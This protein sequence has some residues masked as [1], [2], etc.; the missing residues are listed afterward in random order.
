LSGGLGAGNIR[1]IC[2]PTATGK[3][4]L[5][6]RLAEQFGASIISADSR[7]VY[8]AFNIGTAK[9]SVEE[10]RRIAHYCVDTVDPTERHSAS[11]WAQQAGAAIDLCLANGAVP[12]VVGGTGFYL[13]A[14][15]H[16]LFAEPF[17]DP[18]QRTLLRSHLAG[19]TTAE[20]RRWCARMDAPIT[21]MGRTQLMRAIEVAV[22][23]G[24]R[25]SHLQRTQKQSSHLTPRYLLVDSGAALHDSIRRR[26]HAMFDAG[27][28]N[29]AAKLA[30]EVPSNAPAWKATGYRTVCELVQGQIT[31]EAAVEL[32]TIHTRQYAKRQRTW[33]RHQ[34][35]GASVV[36][37]SGAAPDLMQLASHWWAGEN[38]G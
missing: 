5:A 23:T 8:R 6:L 30:G 26:V 38:G 7:Q 22:L 14:L 17:V 28:E 24:S 3:S 35:R 18:A 32:I 31:K 21:H 12:L 33:F 11:D 13:R 29:E 1:V 20:L 10:R 16:P 27:W 36:S 34:L 4:A 25:L 19:F 2:G 15:F 37:V 9:P